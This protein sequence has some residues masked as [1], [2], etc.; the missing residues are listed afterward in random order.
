MTRIGSLFSGIGGLELGLER[1]G[2]G[3]TVWQVEIDPFRR[4]LLAKHWPRAEQFVDVRCVGSIARSAEERVRYDLQPVEVMCGGFPCQDLSDAARGRGGRNPRNP[5]RTLE[6]I[7]PHRRRAPTC[8]RHSGERWWS[9]SQGLVAR[10]AAFP[11]PARLPNACPFG[12]TRET[13]GLPT[14]E[15][16]SSL[17]ATPTRKH[18]QLA[19]SMRKW[20]GCRR[21]QHLAGT[22]GNPSPELYEWLMGFPPG[23]TRLDD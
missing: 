14:P 20:P 15:P 8:R 17:L 21:L 7:R 3:R 1:A 10:A 9:R 22:G 6:G 5:I 13:L 12:S 11:A 19:P 23:W 18:N 16:A 4:A 2:L